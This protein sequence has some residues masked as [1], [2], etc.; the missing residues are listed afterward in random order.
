MNLLEECHQSILKIAETQ[1][2]DGKKAIL[3]MAEIFQLNSGRASSDRKPSSSQDLYRSD[4]QPT[5]FHQL[6]LRWRSR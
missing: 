5:S 2:P 1:P 4:W 3:A 6:R